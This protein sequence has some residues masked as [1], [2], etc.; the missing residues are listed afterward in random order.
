[1][2]PFCFTLMFVF[3]I[4]L[5]IYPGLFVLIQ[6]DNQTTAII[7]EKFILPLFC[8]LVFN[9]GDFLGRQFGGCFLLRKDQGLASLSIALSRILFIPLFI[10]CNVQPRHIIVLFKS[11]TYFILFNLIFALL[12]GYLVLNSFVNGPLLI[13][14][15]YRQF[16]GYLL[17]AFLGLGLTLGSLTSPFILRILL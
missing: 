3:W 7:P 12:N 4:T 14:E 17:V 5:S 16:S 6:S 8:F 2:W 1:M 10:F 9:L 13:P 11:E 15:Q